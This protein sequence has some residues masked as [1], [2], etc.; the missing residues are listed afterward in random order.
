MTFRYV[1][2][3]SDGVRRE[4]AIDAPSRDEAFA[5]LR[6]RG[7][8]PIKV[9]AADGSRANGEAR[10]RRPS[11]SAAVALA[12]LAVAALAVVLRFS[13]APSARAA[14]V[15]P[16]PRQMIG[17]DRARLEKVRREVFADPAER[18]L[19]RY[20][21]P[22]RLVEDGAPRPSDAAFAACLASPVR[23]REEEWTEAIELKRMVATIKNELAAYLAAGGTVP[24]FLGELDA[25]Q[26]AEAGHRARAAAELEALLADEA[27]HARA[28]AYWLEANAHLQSMGVYPLDL[29]W[30][31]RA[32]PLA[33]RIG[34]PA[35]RE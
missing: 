17:G 29:P 5:R 33:P 1:Y 26:N 15:K 24:A 35:R 22:G 30:A 18:Y 31:L 13:S 7:I 21:E 3:T 12:A 11:V 25:R 2:R 8:R 27:T 32:F 28:Y 10:P 6:T 20:A 4:D 14:A 23:A 34:T 19:A 9:V 16:L